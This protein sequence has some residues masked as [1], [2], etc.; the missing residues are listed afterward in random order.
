MMVDEFVYTGVEE[1]DVQFGTEED[2]KADH[3]R[4][5]ENT[6]IQILASQEGCKDTRNLCKYKLAR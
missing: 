3:R 6:K 2:H 4:K 1:E 5:A